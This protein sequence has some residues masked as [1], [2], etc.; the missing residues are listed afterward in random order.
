MGTKNNNQH[1]KP[2]NEEIKQKTDQVFLVTDEL[3]D[4]YGVD[5]ALNVAEQKGLD[6]VMVAPDSE[7]PV[8]RLMDY[9]KYIFDKRKQEKKNQTKKKKQK[10]IKFTPNTA[11]HD[12]EF[13]KNH[14]REFLK[15]G[16]SVK[17]LVTFKGKKEMES[18]QGQNSAK[19]LLLTIANELEDFGKPNKMPEMDNM[20]MEMLLKPIS[21]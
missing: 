2:V 3:K 17:A 5:E 18:D 11:E 12:L 13:K 9:N 14:I 1:Q 6:L 15:K 16:H 21:E 19:Q 10:T 20:N 7:P 4:N 8:C